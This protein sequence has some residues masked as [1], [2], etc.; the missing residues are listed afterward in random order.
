[1]RI[2]GIDYGDSRTGVA[3]S[4]PF[5]WTAQGLETI[6]GGVEI[7]VTRIVQLARQYE[8][9]IIVVGYPVNM[10]GSVGFRASHTDK[11]IEALKQ[12]IGGEIHNNRG[13][14]NGNEGSGAVEI[15]KW[16]ER[17]TSVQASRVIAESGG[18]PTSRNVREKGRLDILSAAILL[19]SYLD[20]IR[21]AADK[22]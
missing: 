15:I 21:P 14:G 13:G 8:A 18:R 12:R 2:I 22:I 4:D 3:V 20:S 9:G 17:L 5:G 11:F 16:D 1:M 19:Q 6:K 7:V 10:D